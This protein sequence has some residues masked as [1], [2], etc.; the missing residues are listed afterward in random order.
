MDT[1]ALP[2]PADQQASFPPPSQLPG[3]PLGAQQQYPGLLAA[4]TQPAYRSVVRRRTTRIKVPFAEPEQLSPGFVE[5]LQDVAA[6]HGVVLAGV[7]VRPGEQSGN[8]WE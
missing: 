8:G 4:G 6:Q 1:Q 5:R 7:Y 2:L 3:E